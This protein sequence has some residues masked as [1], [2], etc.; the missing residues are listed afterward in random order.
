MKMEY[1]L[2]RGIKIKRKLTEYDYG[3]FLGGFLFFT[4][5]VMTAIVIQLCLFFFSYSI[6]IVL[7]GMYLNV[8][9]SFKIYW[10]VKKRIKKDLKYD[11]EKVECIECS[12]CKRYFLRFK[13]ESTK[14][15]GDCITIKISKEENRNLS[16][17]EPIESEDI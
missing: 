6:L 16:E 7:L 15:C 9:I 13:W 11:K 8:Y 12:N 5:M 4:T 14:L 17:F 3:Y 1:Q 10:F 2:K